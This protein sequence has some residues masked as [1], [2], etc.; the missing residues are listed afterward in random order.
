MSAGQQRTVVRSGVSTATAVAVVNDYAAVVAAL[1]ERLRQHTSLVRVVDAEAG[2]EDVGTVDV[3][4]F[5]TFGARRSAVERLQRMRRRIGTTPIVVLSSDMPTEFVRALDAIP[6][7]LPIPKAITSTVLAEF[8][9]D[10]G[11][12]RGVDRVP[13]GPREV[14]PSGALDD[15]EREVLA[16]LLDGRTDD[17]IGHELMRPV[18]SVAATAARGLRKLG[19]RERAQLP[20]SSAAQ[21]LATSNCN[22]RARDFHREPAQ[23]AVARRFVGERLQDCGADQTSVAVFRLAVSELGANVVEHGTGDP[24]TVCVY[25]SNEWWSVEV[26][27]IVGDRS[28]P[29]LRPGAWHVAEPRASSGRGLGIVRHLMDEVTVV[30]QA[31]RARIVCRRRH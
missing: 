25:G 31:D 26:E 13:F 14:V 18:A 16:L 8:L 7:V 23:V 4:V 6:S 28:G 24:W 11:T 17:E 21:D 27:G 19:V 10:V 22:L 9:R 30:F 2:A 5:D 12:G 1:E 20:G 29:L 3:V 15:D